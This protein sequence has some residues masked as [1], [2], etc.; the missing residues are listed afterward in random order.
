MGDSFRARQAERL[1]R[2]SALFDG[3][4]LRLR[5]ARGETLGV[6]V[7]VRGPE[8]QAIDL[9]LPA[10]VSSVQGFDVR[11]LDVREP[12]TSL[13]GPSRGAGRYSDVL[14]PTNGPVY[15][16]EQAFFDVSIRSEAQPGR[17]DG[18]I[19]IGGRIFPVR[20]RVEPI[21]IEAEVNPLVWVFYHPKE[22]ARLHGV[23]DDDGPEQIA[24]ES[25]YHEL[26]RRHGAYLAADLGPERFAPRRRF[27]QNVRYWPVAVDLS[28]DERTAADVRRWLLLFAGSSVTPFTIPVDE[29]RSDEQKRRV[30]HV[31]EVIGKAGGGAPGLLRAV[32][33][34]ASPI[35]AGVIEAF[36]SPKNF[37]AALDRPNKKNPLFFTYNGRPPEAGSMILDTDGVALRSWGWIAY[38]YGIELWYAWEG[39]YFS[40]RYNG[41]GPTSVFDQAITFD[42]RRRG[43]KDFGNGDGVLAYPGALPSLRLKALRRG[44]QDRLLLLQLE[45]CGGGEQARAI[46]E[47]LLPRALGEAGQTPSWPSDEPPWEA[48]RERVFDAIAW[49]CDAR[50]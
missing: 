27:M 47:R 5:G 9:E 40:D 50:P 39:L 4:T 35:Y 49:R 30:R 24:I 7:L 6:Q 31:A 18:R 1:P 29:P 44:L 13:Y 38:R 43:G 25:K 12:S 19:A 21:S 20:L 41:G 2:D 33:D 16:S 48:A 23:A 34:A 10:E 3:A 36:F 15:A 26:F 17:Y 14:T 28:S 22:L 32:T 11:S 46:A 8:Q 42:E 45:R 37:T